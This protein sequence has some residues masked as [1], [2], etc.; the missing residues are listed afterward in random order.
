MVSEIATS[1]DKPLISF[2]IFSYNQEQFIREAVEGAFSQSYSPLEIVLSDDCSTDMTFEIV[3]EM[4]AAYDGPHKIILNQNTRNLGFGRH[5]N[6]GFGLCS[7]ELIV[8]AAGDDISLATRSASLY[9][10]WIA[11]GKPSMI[12]SGW[13]LIDRYGKQLSDTANSREISPGL[14]RSKKGKANAVQEY[15][16][17]KPFSLVGAAAAYSRELLHCF[18]ALDE[19]IVSED[20]SLCLR[21]LL[22]SDV[23]CIEDVLVQYRRHDNNISSVG[24]SGAER[25]RVWS[26]RHAATFRGLYQDLKHLLDTRSLSWFDFARLGIQANAWVRSASILEQWN[27]AHFLTKLFFLFPGLMLWGSRRHK[28]FA[29]NNIF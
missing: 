11:F 2:I 20:F 1:Q 13:E 12:C 23:L 29:I 9:Q 28:K 10:S 6:Y 22:L 21:A 17:G 27:Q 16:D 26:V 19:N 3:T 8:V 25:F 24:G 4:V 18:P 5:L 14:L 7:G 15:L